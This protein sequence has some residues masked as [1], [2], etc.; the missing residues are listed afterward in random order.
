MVYP[1]NLRKKTT[2]VSDIC[3]DDPSASFLSLNKYISEVKQLII[4]TNLSNDLA[5]SSA[6]DQFCKSVRSKVISISNRAFDNIG[7]TEKNDFITLL[8][9]CLEVLKSI[10]TSLASA[11]TIAKYKE[12]IDTM[13]KNVKEV[14]ETYL[15]AIASN[16]DICWHCGN[17]ATRTKTHTYEKKVERR[18]GYNTKQV[19]TYSKTVTFHICDE[20]AEEDSRQSSWSLIGM[21]TTIVIEIVVAIWLAGNKKYYGWEYNWDWV[22]PLI[23]INLFGGFYITIL[24]GSGIGWVA[25]RLFASGK[26]RKYMREESDHPLV[27]RI[28]KEGFS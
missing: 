12:D 7:K 11:G 23:L 13:S 20:C 2:S 28:K 14:D 6:Y 9:S 8:N 16:E 19:T 15:L 21:I 1:K 27:K 3:I 17:K 26:I 24:L 18:V 22:W 10:D 5:L 25:R 4:S